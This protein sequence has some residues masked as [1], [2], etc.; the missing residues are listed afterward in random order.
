MKLLEDYNDK[1]FIYERRSII[2]NGYFFQETHQSESYIHFQDYQLDAICYQYSHLVCATWIKL[3]EVSSKKKLK[4]KRW[5]M[6][7]IDHEWTIEGRI[8]LICCF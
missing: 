4:G 2:W 3:I 8:P 7:N 6:S 1:G 5:K